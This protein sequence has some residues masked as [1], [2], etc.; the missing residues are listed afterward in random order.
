MVKHILK[1]KKVAAQIKKEI[2]RK[3]NKK[4]NATSTSK[5]VQARIKRKSVVTNM[6]TASK[7]SKDEEDEEEDKHD[8]DM[9][10]HKN[11]FYKKML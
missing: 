7:Q 8:I 4:K 6:G 9:T 3:M 5:A 10:I 11:L 2:I 1:P